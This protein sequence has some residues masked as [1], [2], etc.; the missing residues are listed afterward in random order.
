MTTSTGD[1]GAWQRLGTALKQRRVTLDQ[2]FRNRKAF[3]EATGLDYRLIYDIE[4][5]RRTNFG[6]A[7]LTAIEVGYRLTP[8]SIARLLAGGSLEPVPEDAPR[9]ALAAVP[10]ES[11]PDD[12]PPSPNAVAFAH[13]FGVTDSP[14]DPFVQ[15]V[16]RDIADAIMAYGAS[17]S[18]GQIFAGQ[19]WSAD[20]ARLWDD[21]RIPRADKEMFIAGMRAE[22]APH[23]AGHGDGRARI[24]LPHP[25]ASGVT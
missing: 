12:S 8:G 10:A 5:S 25:A 4:E 11:L 13:A 21:P 20:E 1:T 16:R 22:R 23:E 2:R 7:T 24:G 18:G 9:P 19:P 6:V 14:S 3:A 15:S 17:A